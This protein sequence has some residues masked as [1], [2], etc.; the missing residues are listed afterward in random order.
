MYKDIRTLRNGV[1]IHMKG[2]IGHGLH[3][4]LLESEKAGQ[5]FHCCIEVLAVLSGRPR[6]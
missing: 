4:L 2:R 1:Y 5:N 6:F 3:V